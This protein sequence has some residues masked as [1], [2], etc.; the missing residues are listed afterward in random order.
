VSGSIVH[1]MRAGSSYLP[2]TCG[3]IR[4]MVLL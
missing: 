1:I 4:D 2:A 3:D